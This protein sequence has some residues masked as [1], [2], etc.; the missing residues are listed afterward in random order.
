MSEPDIPTRIKCFY[1]WQCHNVAACLK[2]IEDPD[3][4]SDKDEDYLRQCCVD[5][6][7]RPVTSKYLHFDFEISNWRVK[8]SCLLIFG[9]GCFFSTLIHLAAFLCSGDCSKPENTIRLNLFFLSKAFLYIVLETGSVLIVLGIIRQKILYYV[10]HTTYSILITGS[11]SIL[12]LILVAVANFISLLLFPKLRQNRAWDDPWMVLFG[13]LSLLITSMIIL[14]LWG[15]SL[16]FRCLWDQASSEAVNLM[17][18]GKLADIE[19]G[20]GV[21]K[22]MTDHGV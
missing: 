11:F 2:Y 14:I 3:C 13:I 1:F 4:M 19:I 12:Y 20:C 7:D 21:A 9:L 15:C 17:K 5:V 6:S 18:Q 16:C 8:M 10:Q 22:Q